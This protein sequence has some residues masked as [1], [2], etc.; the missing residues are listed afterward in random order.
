MVVEWEEDFIGLMGNYTGISWRLIV[1][2]LDLMGFN[3]LYH[4]YPLVNV[5]KTMERSTMLFMGK[6]T[7]SMVIFQF[8]FCMLPEG[9]TNVLFKRA[10]LLHDSTFFS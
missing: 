4:G 8:T 9:T 5:Y 10:T 3:G 2:Y 6:L 7:I 1:I